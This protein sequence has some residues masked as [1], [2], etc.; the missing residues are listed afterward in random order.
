[1]AKSTPRRLWLKV[2]FKAGGASRKMV[3]ETLLRSIHKGDYKYPKRWRVALEW[4][5]NEQGKLKIGE[6]EREMTKS[7]ESSTG[8]DIAVA[9]YLQDQLDEL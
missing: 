7:A 5:N 6:W 8:W 4:S 1:M 2:K 3:L 9:Q